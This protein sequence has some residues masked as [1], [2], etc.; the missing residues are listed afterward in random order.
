MDRSQGE[1]LTERKCRNDNEM[2]A[3]PEFKAQL[4]VGDSLCFH[5]DFETLKHLHV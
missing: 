4:A 2:G 5:F 1:R 3:W